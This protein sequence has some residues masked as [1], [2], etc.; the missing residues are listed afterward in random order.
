MKITIGE[1]KVN[2][3]MKRE[4]VSASVDFEGGP[5]PSMAAFRAEVSKHMNVSEDR[6]QVI[7]MSSHTG[8]TKG[9]AWLNVWESAELV[10]KPKVKAVPAEKK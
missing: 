8:L 10:P 3:V 5:T 4:E 2:P 9:Q 1:K 7:K 6:I